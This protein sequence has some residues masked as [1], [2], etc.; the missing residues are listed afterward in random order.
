MQVEFMRKTTEMKDEFDTQEMAK[1]FATVRA[2]S[3]RHI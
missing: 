1:T 3:C 2:P